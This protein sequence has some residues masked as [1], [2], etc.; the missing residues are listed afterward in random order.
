MN[1]HIII[2]VIKI[3]TLHLH[4]KLPL[5]TSFQNASPNNEIIFGTYSRN[6]GSKNDISNINSG[7]VVALR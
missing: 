7:I 2:N 5:L 1:L 4:T 6:T 3:K